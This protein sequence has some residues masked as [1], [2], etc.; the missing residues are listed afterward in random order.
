MKIVIALFLVFHSYPGLAQN[1][2]KSPESKQFD[3]WIG[4]WDIKQEILQGDGQWLKLN[5]KTEVRP[6]WDGCGM[7]ESWKGDVQFFWE[8]MSKP[9][10]MNGYSMRYFDAAKQKW[11][12]QWMDSRTKGTSI[13]EGEFT[14]G[15]GKFYKYDSSENKA[16]ITKI[17]FSD[18][19]TNKVKWE[20]AVSSDNQRTWQPLWIMNM[21]RAKK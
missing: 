12:L 16:T 13:F 8:G 17:T 14:E 15:V 21:S 18:F 9:E 11:T 3:F 1:N 19:S 10:S 2:C 5:A 20:L 6:I 7:V 4:K